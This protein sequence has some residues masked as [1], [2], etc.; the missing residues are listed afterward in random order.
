MRFMHLGPRVFLVLFGALGVAAAGALLAESNQAGA[1]AAWRQWGG[2]GRNFVVDGATLANAW[3]ASGPTE[4]WRR[5]LGDG[6]SSILLDGGRLYTLYRPAPTD[7]AK[8]ASEEIVVALDEATGDTLWE[9]RYPARPQAFQFGAGPFTTPLI[10]GERLFSVGTNNQLFALDAATGSVLWSHDLVEEFGAQEA[11]VRA[12]V[13]AGISS[14]PIAWG[15]TVI[16]TAGGEGQSVMAFDQA[17]GKVVWRSGDFYVSHSSP[18]LIELN[19]ETQLVVLGGLDVYGIDPDTGDILWNHPHNTRGDMNISTPHW[20]DG[21]LLFLSSA[22]DGGSRMLRLRADGDRT[23][24][25][26]LWFTNQLR[27]HIGN[28][29]RVD[30]MMIGSNGDFGPSFVTALDVG[31]GE[32]LWQDRAFSRSRFL[33]LG[34][35][36]LVLD[37]DG[38]LGLVRAARDGLEVLARA[39]VLSSL[40]WTAPTLVGSQLYLRDRQEIVKL[41]LPVARP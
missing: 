11:M 19:G 16:V 13:K 30:D 5:P 7:G 3:P 38:V 6:H 8:W 41:R 12:A 40:A 18:I 2:P 33:N 25:E 35:K 21:N 20:S 36:L 37:E 29:V 32:R 31:T 17:S 28:A 14:S 23:G 1:D 34:D 10:V 27:L 22:Y 9:H 26:E 39:E 15:D 4:V 24:A